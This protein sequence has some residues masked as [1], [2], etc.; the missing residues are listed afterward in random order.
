MGVESFYLNLRFQPIDISPILAKYQGFC[1]FSLDT[2]ETVHTLCM[3]G[4]KAAFLPVCGVMYDICCEI[5]A[6]SPEPVSVETLRQTRHRVTEIERSNFVA[7]MYLLWAEYLD[8]F[9]E[10]FGGFVMLPSAYYDS[11]SKLKKYY[12]KSPK[13]ANLHAED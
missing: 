4:A 1:S 11:R 12:L 2:A 8:Y 10:E 3:Q 7:W 9:Y 6:I 5:Q 13:G